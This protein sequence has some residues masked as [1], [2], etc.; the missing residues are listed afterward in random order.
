MVNSISK[1]V[2]QDNMNLV[3]YIHIGEV[4]KYFP[5]RKQF[6]FSYEQL[7][8]FNNNYVVA[9]ILCIYGIVN[10]ISIGIIRNPCSHIAIR[11]NATM[12][13]QST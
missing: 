10:V 4:P 9:H 2:C 6:C 7:Y 5:I 8:D 1:I 3:K 11:F 13:F 12:Y